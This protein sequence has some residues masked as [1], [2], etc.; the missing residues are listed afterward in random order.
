MSDTPITVGRKQSRP[1]GTSQETA[2][3]LEESGGFLTGAQSCRATSLVRI[4][5]PAFNEERDLPLL[6][7]GIEQTMEQNS[8]PYEVIVVNDGSTDGTRSIAKEAA[9]DMPLWLIDHDQNRGL[10]GALDSGFRTALDRA[11]PDDVIIT[12]DA[13]NT[14]PPG[15]IPRMVTMVREGR[16]VV[17]ASRFER[18]AR[19]IGV[20]RFRGILTLGAR[21]TFGLLFPIRGVHDY[22]SSFRAF[23]AS[24]IREALSVYGESFVSETGF[25]CMVDV[26]LKLRHQRPVVGEV[27]LV[28][29]YDRKV[30]VSKMRVAD[31][32]VQT[33]RLVV[34]RRLE[35][36][37]KAD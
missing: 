6:L 17:I 29:R 14:H 8:V 13:D 37:R 34:R 15:L 36:N 32:I 22:T 16:D 31:T 30:G 20:P 24:V 27:P 21:L 12:M 1:E 25:S 23:R 4:V 28:L 11:N 2:P 26:L 35:R 9:C 5:L 18:G 7:E 33:L 10:A 3:R 19:V